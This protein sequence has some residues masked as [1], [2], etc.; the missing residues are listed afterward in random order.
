MISSTQTAT[1]S[2]IRLQGRIEVFKWWWLVVICFMELSS[3]I[4]Y[5]KHTARFFPM[6]WNVKQKQRLS[7]SFLL[8][9]KSFSWTHVH[10]IKNAE[11]ARQP[12]TQASSCYPSYQRR[13]GAECGPRR[14]FPTSSTGDVTSKFA[15]D[16]WER[17]C[18]LGACGRMGEDRRGNISLTN[19]LYWILLEKLFHECEGSCKGRRYL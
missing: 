14:I 8:T 5:K 2:V 1:R 16:D 3:L 7:K 10:F 17:G 12:R 9:G 15:E 19:L 13:L 11:C 6:T 4:W 18:V